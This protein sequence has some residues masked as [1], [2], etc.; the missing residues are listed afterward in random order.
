MDILM[1]NSILNGGSEYPLLRSL[2]VPPLDSSGEL[3]TLNNDI[4]INIYTL[5]LTVISINFV[6]THYQTSR[7]ED[8]VK[9][10][11]GL[12]LGD[13][14]S[15]LKVRLR[16]GLYKSY[17]LKRKRKYIIDK[18]SSLNIYIVLSISITSDCW[19]CYL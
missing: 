8:C 13:R 16:A 4:I 14:E 5:I 7:S 15:I 6:N 1:P 2:S 11:S 10:A 12:L 18:G 3:L 17:I 9:Q 19:M